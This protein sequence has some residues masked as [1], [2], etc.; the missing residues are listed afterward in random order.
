MKQRDQGYLEGGAFAAVV[1]VIIAVITLVIGGFVWM[2]GSTW[3]S[4]DSAAA[5]CVYNGGPFDS[6]TYKGDVPPGTGRAYQGFAS[7]VIEYPVGII[8]LDASDGMQ[9]IPVSVGGFTQTYSPVVS[10]TIASY[11]DAEGKPQGC[12]LI[13]QHLKRLG[14]TDFNDDVGN[15]RWVSQFLLVR[16]APAVKDALPR[17][18]SNG[19]PTDLFLNQDSARDKAAGEVATKANESLTASLG[20]SY[21]CGTSYR[22]G[23]PIETCGTINV[24]LPEPTMSDGDLAIIRAP[25]EARTKASNDIDVANERARAAAGVAAA[26]TQEALS[27]EEQAIADKKIAEEKAKSEQVI[28]AN[29]YIW[30]EHLVSL[31]QDCALVKAAENKNFPTVIG[32]ADV[33]VPLPA[34]PAPAG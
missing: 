24:V 31:G 6:K 22:Y 25:Q 10:F 21:F 33:V 28:V 11:K 16:V 9:P 19:D 15:S 3:S 17:V 5:A 34:A 14:A 26:R 20:G 13:E 7:K 27:A 8:Q 18:L 4:T 23:Q 29:Q 30:C 12:H 1:V 32:Q 2:V